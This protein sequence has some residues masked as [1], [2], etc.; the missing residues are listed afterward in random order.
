MYIGRVSGP[1]L[2]VYRKGPFQAVHVTL[3]SECVMAEMNP[4]YWGF[5]IAFISILFCSHANCIGYVY[6]Y[7]VYVSY[8]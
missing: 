1:L 6:L 2:V 8:Y 5:R 4:K 3:A 7:Q